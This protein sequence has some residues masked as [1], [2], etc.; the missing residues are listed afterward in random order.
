MHTATRAERVAAGLGIRVL[1]PSLGMSWID[2][3]LLAIQRH[4]VP[5][6][7]LLHVP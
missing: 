2:Q 3:R 1:P 7:Y 6:L 5:K 4:S